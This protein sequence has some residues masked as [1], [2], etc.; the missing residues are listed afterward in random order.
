MK[1]TNI[2]SLI[3]RT[4]DYLSVGET[5]AIRKEEYEEFCCPLEMYGQ[6]KG[7][8]VSRIIDKFDKHLERKDY[9]SAEKHLKYW[10][11]EAKLIGD[12]RGMLAVLNEMIGLFRKNS[13][14]ENALK[15]AEQAILLAQKL[16]LDGTVAMGTTL[17][18]AATAYKSFG[19][20]ELAVPLFEAARII[21]EK[22]LNKNDVRL[23][24]LYNN[25]GIAEGEIGNYE[26]AHMLFN[27]AIEIMNNCENGELE[28][29]ITY[30]NLAN[31]IHM[32]L[33]IQD[34]DEIICEYIEK[35]ISLFD[36]PNLTRNN[37]YAFVCEKCAPTIGY[38]GYFAAEK[39]LLKRAGEIYE[40]S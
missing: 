17:V 7:I 38:Y 11:N 26:N 27:N 31:L 13:N 15:A 25:A 6:Q 10:Y 23:G 3:F 28:L 9:I 4:A 22:K 5:M 32:E 37:Y 18:N 36:L 34:G 35:A 20:P 39:E 33:G 30:C 14:K 1:N 19:M 40:R 24:A 12:N 29:A 2:R 8:P 21:Y 16:S